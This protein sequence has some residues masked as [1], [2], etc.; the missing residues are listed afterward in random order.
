MPWAYRRHR[1]Y[2]SPPPLGTVEK[3]L[4]LVGVVALLLTVVLRLF[5]RSS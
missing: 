3:I 5:R 2:N 1:W 4:L